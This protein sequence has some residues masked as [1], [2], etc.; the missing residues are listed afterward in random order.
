MKY[1]SFRTRSPPEAIS[2][3]NITTNLTTAVR[4]ANPTLATAA[5]GAQNSPSLKWEGNAWDSYGAL[6][7]KPVWFESYVVAQAGA[8]PTSY[9]AFAAKTHGTHMV[10]T[11]T[12]NVGIGTDAPEGMLDIE[13][14][15]ATSDVYIKGY[16]T[17]P[18]HSPSLNLHKS[19]SDTLGTVTTTADGDTIG[20]IYFRGVNAHGT[21]AFDYGAW[22]KAKQNGDATT[23]AVPTDLIFETYGDS[24][25][26]NNQL[27]LHHDGN[28]GIGTTDPA[29]KLHVNGDVSATTLK[30]TVGIGTAP[31]EITSTTVV[32][33]LNADLLDGQH[34]AYYAT[35][36][37]LIA[38]GAIVDT[39]TTNL[40][41]TGAIVDDVAV[42]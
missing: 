7:S 31:L 10:I 5:V 20:D 22:I 39:N 8:T 11:N 16:G 41:L 18:I 13:K 37:N 35:A 19:N 26:N 3:P 36:A 6:E 24:A 17:S 38:T 4:I 40:I 23:T 34:G 15:A 9:L 28:V 30:S 33:N 1:T 27:I 32:T 14:A 42:T 12:G 29:A 2:K 21:P 25:R